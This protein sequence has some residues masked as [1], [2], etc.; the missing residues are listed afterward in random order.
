MLNGS[1]VLKP[2]VA[3]SSLYT[4]ISVRPR[5]SH[6]SAVVILGQARSAARATASACVRC[7][8]R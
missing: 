5:G 7:A 4:A 3:S 2:L 8:A 1:G 6:C